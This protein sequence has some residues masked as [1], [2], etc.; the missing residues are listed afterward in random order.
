MVVRPHGQV[1][2]GDAVAAKDILAVVEQGVSAGLCEER[3]KAVFRVRLVHANLSV[4]H[5]VMRR[6]HRHDEVH[7]AVTAEDGVEV[8]RVSGGFCGGN[9]KSIIVVILFVTKRYG[10][11]SDGG[12]MHGEVQ[13]GGAV[14]AVH[15][16]VHVTVVLR[17]QC[18]FHSEIVVVVGL[19]VADVR[20]DLTA[21]FGAHVEV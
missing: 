21:L 11:V 1:Q 7:G 2:F 19:A 4:Q 17:L 12:M 16:L 13:H 10:N 9:T 18:L 15:I 8:L 3:V 5:H 20:V 6:V 14:A